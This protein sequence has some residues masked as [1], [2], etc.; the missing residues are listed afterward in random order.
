MPNTQAQVYLDPDKLLSE[1]ASDSLRRL[2]KSLDI[3]QL[4]RNSY[5][6]HGA[7]LTK[8]KKA[9]IRLEPWSFDPTQ[10]FLE[11][12]RFTVRLKTIKVGMQSDD[13]G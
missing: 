3:L 1:D 10:V 7:N 4:Y 6:N 9:G 2:Q 11:L 12:D 13:L 5:E 8:Y